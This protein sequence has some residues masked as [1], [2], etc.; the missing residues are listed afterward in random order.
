MPCIPPARLAY[1][2][3]MAKRADGD[4]R[5]RQARGERRRQEILDAA[6]EL[7]A[8]K[9]F[10]A[11]DVTELAERVGMTRPGVLYYFGDKERLL[12]E[13]LVER[14]RVE[15]TREP[16]MTLLGI[17]DMYAEVARSV[18]HDRLFH[19]LSAESFDPDG[20]LHD[21][22]VERYALAR[23][24]WRAV[25][26]AEQESGRA[27]DDIDVDQLSSEILGVLLGIEHQWLMDPDS[28]D[29]VSLATAYLDR[30]RHSIAP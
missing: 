23:D 20:P 11:A 6:V 15:V 12:R 16:P 10:R 8:E 7:F 3:S 1:R 30:L 18:V 28:I 5:N 27:R 24:W 13:A 29:L 2:G 26:L 22:F 21:F 17:R 4:A 25:L 19:V 9:G 14:D